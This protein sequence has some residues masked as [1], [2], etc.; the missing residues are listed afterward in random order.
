[1]TDKTVIGIPGGMTQEQLSKL[2][3]S[4]P[5]TYS[6]VAGICTEQTVSHCP[7]EECD[8]CLL[9]WADN[10]TIWKQVEGYEVIQ[11]TDITPAN[12]QLVVH[13]DILERGHPDT[14]SFL[15]IMVGAGATINMDMDELEDTILERRLIIEMEKIE[16]EL[17]DES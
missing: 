3:G 8:G 15:Q 9:N 17:D 5:I 10:P 1:M 4:K 14:L 13:A 7:T 16:E 11:L 12:T 6:V 2:M